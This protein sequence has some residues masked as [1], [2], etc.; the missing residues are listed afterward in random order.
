MGGGIHV[1]E[2]VLNMH[3]RFQV[4]IYFD[5]LGC[6]VK[7]T[8]YI[9]RWYVVTLW[10]SVFFM[11][12]HFHISQTKFTLNMKFI[13]MFVSCHKSASQCPSH[14]KCFHVTI[15]F[16]LNLSWSVISLFLSHE[17]WNCTLINLVYLI[18]NF[19]YGCLT[20]HFLPAYFWNFLIALVNF[21]FYS[22]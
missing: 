15:H 16:S 8:N 18:L 1:D 7:L 17:V 4:R 5:R 2:M 20:L 9:E 6:T 19:S 10:Q 14:V 3:R 12:C 11:I 13:C 22:P 21:W